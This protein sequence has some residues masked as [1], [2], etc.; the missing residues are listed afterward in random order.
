MKNAHLV[1][2]AL[3]SA[4]CGGGGG[5]GGTP[6]SPATTTTTAQAPPAQLQQAVQNNQP[7]PAAPLPAAID[8]QLRAALAQNGVQVPAAP[9]AQNQARVNLGEFLMFDKI[10]SGNRDIACATCHAVAQNTSDGLSLSIGTGGTLAGPNRVLGNGRSFIARNSQSLFNLPLSGPL[11]WDGRVQNLNTPAGNQL[12]AGLDNSIAA[13]ALFPVLSREEM[14]GQPGENDLANLDPNTPGPI[15]AGLMQRVLAIPEYVNLFNLAF[16]GVPT[17]QLGIQHA[18]NAIAAFEIDKGTRLNSPFDQYLRG[19]DAAMTEAQKR[20]AILFYGRARCSLCHTG[21]ILSDFQFKNIAAPQVGPG[22]APEAPLDFGRARLT[23]NL[24]DRFRFRTPPLRN[25]ALT[26]PWMHAGAYTTLDAAVRHYINPANALRNYNANQLAPL[27]RT[28]V[29]VQQQIAAGIL[30]GLDPLLQPVA[31]NG[32]E[33]ADL[34]QF[35]NALT[36]PG[37]TPA[38]PARVPSGLPVN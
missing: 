35:L 26:G 21:G 37:A 22:L 31:L 32:G 14:L 15:W 11:F 20:G 36:D 27:L 13:Q 25:V 33:V 24:N 28:Q 6:E 3:L 4:G 30:D 34:V 5:G 18:A 19:D 17:N 23:N 9:A 16:P 38:P 8:V 10:L 1:L 29:R 7:A 2:L 12:P